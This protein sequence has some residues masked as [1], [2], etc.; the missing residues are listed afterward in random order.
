MNTISGKII[1]FLP[2][3]SGETERGAWIRGGIVIESVTETD[4][5]IAIEVFGQD[6]I[7][8]IRQLRVGEIVI[9]DYRV[10]SRFYVDKWFTTA[11]FV[12]VMRSQTIGGSNV[13]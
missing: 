7:D 6:K 4:T 9:V 8:L 10:S 11:S 5:R 2:E 13:G 12:R 1:Q 3:V